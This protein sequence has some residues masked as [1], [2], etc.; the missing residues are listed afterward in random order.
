MRALKSTLVFLAIFVL[1]VPAPAHAWFGWLD[2]LSGPGPFIGAAVQYRLAC[3]DD[4]KPRE[5]VRA[6]FNAALQRTLAQAQLDLAI[7]STRPDSDAGKKINKTVEELLIAVQDALNDVEGARQTK[8]DGQ[9]AFENEVQTRRDL[10]D[11]GDGVLRSLRSFDGSRPKLAKAFGGGCLVPS[12][13]EE[14]DCLW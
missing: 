7:K 3:I 10:V 9:A 2:N 13:E 11:P 6:E 12:L 4:P 8:F 5:N 14:S 1:F